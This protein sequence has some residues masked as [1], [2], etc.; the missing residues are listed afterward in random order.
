MTPLQQ[1]RKKKK[2]P[3]EVPAPFQR[4][5]SGS[6]VPKGVFLPKQAYL[7][8]KTGDMPR[9]T[10]PDSTPVRPSWP[11]VWA[12][13]PPEQEREG[14]RMDQSAALVLALPLTSRETLSKLW[15]HQGL[16]FSS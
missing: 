1:N 9:R 6:T 2:R 10:A 14:I 3:L 7:S 8:H 4:S 11:V 16:S 5:F 13:P 15:S 12:L